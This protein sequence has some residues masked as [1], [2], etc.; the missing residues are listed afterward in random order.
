MTQEI[1]R[2]IKLHFADADTLTNIAEITGNE[3][4]YTAI[5]YLTSWSVG[6][7]NYAFCEI[8]GGVYDGNPE[9]IATYRAEERGVI[10]Y[11][12]G[13]VWHEG[14]AIDG[15][16]GLRLAGHFGFHS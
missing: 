13:A 9:L 1:N 7:A 6:S 12:I 15:T 14:S 8:F 4:L 2:A 11:Q 3:K 5:G 10:T 16:T